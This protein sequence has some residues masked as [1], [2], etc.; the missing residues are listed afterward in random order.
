MKQPFSEAQVVH[1]EAQVYDMRNESQRTG[2]I[3][4]LKGNLLGMSI[5]SPELDFHG[6][7]NEMFRR[8]M[9]ISIGLKRFTIVG[10]YSFPSFEYSSPKHTKP[11]RR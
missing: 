4:V 8:L 5:S 2:L 7:K 6:M 1:N 3:L 9:S 10:R 11:I